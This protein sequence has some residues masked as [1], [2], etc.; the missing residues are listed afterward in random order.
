MSTLGQG[1]ASSFRCVEIGFQRV[2]KDYAFPLHGYLSY[3]GPRKKNLIVKSQGNVYRN[4]EG[5]NR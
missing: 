2:S 5:N 3:N 1:L 4:N